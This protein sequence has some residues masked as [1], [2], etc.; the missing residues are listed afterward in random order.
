MRVYS[1]RPLWGLG[2]LSVT[3]MLAVSAPRAQAAPLKGGTMRVG[4]LAD[5]VNYDPQ[6]LS[7]QN[8]AIIKDLYDSLI[9]YTPTGEP[10]PSLASAWT[11]APDK[12]SVTLTLRS[13]AHFLDGTPLAAADVAATLTKAD[14]PKRGKNIYPTM[15]IVA[16]W[17]VNGPHSITISFKTP[18]PDREITDLLQSIAVIEANGIAT[19]D[20]K[21]A[22][23]GPYHVAHRVVGQS[24][25]LEA[26]PGYW[27]KGEPVS[28]EVLLKIFSE[29]AA[30]TASLQSGGVDLVYG[31]T[32]RSAARLSHLGYQVIRGPG[33][34]V[35]VFR[36]NPNR[37]PFRNE[38]FREAFNYLMNRQAILAI[39]Y[40]GMGEVVSLPWAPS[41]PAF[42]ASYTKKYAF[43]LAKA[44]ALLKE[45][46]LTPAQ[47]SDWKL[48]VD[49]SDQPSVAISQI[50][51]STLAQ[52]GIKIQLDL[53]QGSQFVDNL[54]G[55]KFDAVFG[56]VGNVQKFP[57]RLDTN[58]IYRTVNNVILG[59]PN[60]FPAYVAAIN[61]INT[62][63]GPESAIK[64]A[65]ANLNH[66]LV[67][68]AFGIPTNTYNVGLIVA[69]KNV[70]GFTV[71]I[72]DMLVART[73]GFRN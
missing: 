34:L 24:I 19:V 63:L 10:V 31:G 42:D 2:L 52:V 32:S 17:T 68:T 40:A 25:R 16:G 33:A 36:I 38:K 37:G 47:M 30:A 65:Y 6:Q 28:K 15:S 70:G 73:L 66:V 23:I 46:G 48:L 61:R 26:N 72:D 43:N 29:D 4:I 45:S 22:G 3:A 21:P 51:Q 58:S 67:T 5:I 56:G 14:D 1:R 53:Q 9:E 18:V 13:D 62:T 49:G 71:D 35:Q 20:T 8:F 11:I 64:A 54:L 12:K 39:G 57:S 55:G 69:N 60:P 27:R 44:E 41:S 50:V 59:S 7:S